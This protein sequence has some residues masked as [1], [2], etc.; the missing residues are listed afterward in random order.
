M[1]LTDRI[2]KGKP[3]TVLEV[4]DLQPESTFELEDIDVVVNMPSEEMPAPS[5]YLS[6]RQKDGQVLGA[7]ALYTETWRWLRDRGSEKFVNPRLIEATLRL[8]LGIFSAKKPSAPMACWGS[9][10]LRGRQWLAPL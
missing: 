7:D 1:P 9:I 5:D 10:Q 6:A 4:P 2:L 3:A 8:S